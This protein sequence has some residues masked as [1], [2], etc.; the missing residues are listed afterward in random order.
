METSRHDFCSVQAARL[1][2]WNQGRKSCKHFTHLNYSLLSTQA[3][4]CMGLLTC[5]KL[6]IH[7]TA[8]SKPHLLLGNTP[9]PVPSSVVPAS[10]FIFFLLCRMM[11]K[12]HRKSSVLLSWILAL[13]GLHECK[14]KENLEQK[15]SNQCKCCSTKAHMTSREGPQGNKTLDKVRGGC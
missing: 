4:M 5:Q 1:P 10:E 13:K 8:G 12:A 15:L 3:H 11:F 2:T 14:G 6:L 9:R 7:V